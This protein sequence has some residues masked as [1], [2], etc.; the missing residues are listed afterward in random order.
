MIQAPYQ[1]APAQA[2]SPDF[3]HAAQ[4]SFLL[5]VYFW[6]AIG[7]V[8]TAGVSTFM[9]VP[10]A[11]SYPLAFELVRH[12]VGI[13]YLM[14]LGELGLVIVFSRKARTASAALA[15]VLFIIYAVSNGIT[16]S[17][18]LLLYLRTNPGVLYQA[19]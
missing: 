5:K 17:P 1:A 16:L 3:V 11:N 12:H 10:H 15:T 9:L 4:R 19:F 13:F 6:M 2:L 8:L 7:L 18:L 14:L